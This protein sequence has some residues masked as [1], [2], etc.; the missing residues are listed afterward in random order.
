M[1]LLQFS[2]GMKLLS[3]SYR[4]QVSQE[5]I[6]V[7][8]DLLKDIPYGTFLESI[9]SLMVKSKFF[10]SVAEI[11][12]ESKSINKSYLLF[13]AELMYKDGY[14]HKG[15]ERLSDEHALRNYEKS[16]MWLEKGIIP[17]FL[18][19]DMNVYINKFDNRIE[20]KETKKLNDVQK[21]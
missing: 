20:E 21:L 15:V 6:V 3:D 11:L 7:W 17:E 10:P 1:T 2:K 18:K 16:T 12:E 14:F 4:K 5:T 8:Y 19:E 9:K 13:I